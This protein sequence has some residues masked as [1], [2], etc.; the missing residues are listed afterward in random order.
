[1]LLPSREEFELEVK[2]SRPKVSLEVPLVMFVWEFGEVEVVRKGLT[3]NGEMKA[4]R[5]NIACS[6][7]ICV[8]EFFPYRLSRRTFPPEKK[9]Q[10]FLYLIHN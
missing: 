10:C 9:I 3:I 5:P 1:M 2:L 7:C 8:S 4:P 6:P